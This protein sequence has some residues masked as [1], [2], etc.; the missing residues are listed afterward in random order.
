M[1][2][3]YTRDEVK[4]HKTMASGVWIIIGSSVYD[5][6]KFLEEVSASA[7]MIS[8]ERELPIS[9]YKVV[10]AKNILRTRKLKGKLI[11]NLSITLASG[12]G[13]SA[14]G[15]GGTRCYAGLSGRWP[16][17]RC[18]VRIS[19]FLFL[20]KWLIKNSRSYRKTLKKYKIGDLVKADKK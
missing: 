20:R 12:R 17:F 9:C 3:E 8:R 15:K 2:K 10:K 4:Q 6:T 13:R 19:I 7:N 11:T 14:I 18:Q 16:Q 1:G 5:V